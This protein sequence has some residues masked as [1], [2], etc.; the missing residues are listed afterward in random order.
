MVNAGRV[1][2]AAGHFLTGALVARLGSFALAASSVAVVYLAG[3][4]LLAKARE[5]RGEMLR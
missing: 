4:L 1:L 3:I 5:T 2:A